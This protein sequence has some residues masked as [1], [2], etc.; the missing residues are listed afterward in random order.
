MFREQLEGRIRINPEVLRQLLDML[1]V[2][3]TLQGLRV[4]R[5]I[6]PFPKPRLHLCA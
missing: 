1:V 5:H 2:E 3:H 6:L 4:D